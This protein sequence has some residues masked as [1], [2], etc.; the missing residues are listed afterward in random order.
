ML[1]RRGAM[2]R[3]LLDLLLLH[4]AAAMLHRHA[5]LPKS[6]LRTAAA[7]L[8]PHLLRAGLGTETD[9]LRALRAR[10]AL[11]PMRRDGLSPG[12]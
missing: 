2:R 4:R 1:L 5:D 7:H 8:L 11:S 10:G 9:H 3:M 12:L 6:H